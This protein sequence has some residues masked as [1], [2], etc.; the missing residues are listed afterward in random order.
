MNLVPKSLK[1]PIIGETENQKNPMVLLKLFHPASNWTWYLLEYDP[2]EEIAFGLVDGHEIELGYFSIN[3]LKNVR[4][5]GLAIERDL[6]WKP[7]PL[8]ELQ[9]KLK[10]RSI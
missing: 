9:E 8:S 1:I 4:V 7:I 5:R 10:N 3:E 2:D 6:Y